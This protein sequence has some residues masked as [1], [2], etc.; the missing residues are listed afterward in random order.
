MM[1]DDDP[2]LLATISV[3]VP[4]TGAGDV[5]GV[6]LAGGQARRMGGQDKGLIGL[7]GRPLVEYALAALAAQVSA[8]IINANRNRD[9]YA[10]FGYP[11]V[12]DRVGDFSGPLAGMA[13]AMSAAATRWVVTVPC[14]SP[15]IPSDL[16]GRLQQ[17]REQA[18]AELAVAYAGERLQPVFALLDTALLPSLEEFLARGERKIDRW[19]AEHRCARA[20]FSDQPEAFLNVNTPEDL[21]RLERDLAARDTPQTSR[22]RT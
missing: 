10:G 15:L 20:D 21:Q 2:D 22:S 18:D 12:A 1:R 5:T 3:R 14:D 9:R 13:S 4:V 7:A 19:Y 11:V 8:L 17:A 16:V 6:I